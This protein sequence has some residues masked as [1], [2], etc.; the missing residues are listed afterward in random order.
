MPGIGAA[1]KYGYS[2]TRVKAMGSK[3]IKKETFERMLAAKEPESMAAM[4]LQTDYKSDVEKLGGVKAMG[5]LIDFVLS[6]NLGRETSKLISIAPKDQRDIITAIAGVWDVSNIKLVIEAASS[7]KSF[8]DFS[9]YIIDSKYVG[10]ETVREALGAKSVEG[11][12]EKLM[13]KTPYSGILRQ[14]LDAYKKGHSSLDASGALENA[15]YLQLGSTIS[16]L[17][18]ID[19]EAAALIRKRID[20]RNI[21]MLMEAKR[22]N[23]DPVGVL[24]RILPNGSI[25]AQRLE[26]LY[27]DSKNVESLAE[28]VKRFNLK[29]AIAEYSASKSKPLL[30]FEIAMLNEIFSDALRGVRHSNLSF[31]VIIAFL[32]LKEIEVFTLRILIKG[33]SYGLSDQEIRGMISWLK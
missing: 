30:L 5:T 4:L 3:L 24:A 18:K 14:A 15:Y 20:M 1:M 25:S 12:I 28:G 6:K 8:D 10:P 27:R 22:Q 33:K 29:G 23:S 13:L 7:G 9:R 16:S 32:Y 21:L 11:A 17:M 31:G 2:N 26:K 19:N